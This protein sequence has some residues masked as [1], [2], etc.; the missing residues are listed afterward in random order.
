MKNT[1][2]KR[3]YIPPMIVTER[4]ELEM[5]IAAGSA[6]VNP[7]SNT[8]TIQEEWDKGTDRNKDFDW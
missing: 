2:N 6:V 7:V 8:G 5:G 1:I 3:G 4:I